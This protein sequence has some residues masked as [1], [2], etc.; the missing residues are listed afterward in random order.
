MLSRVRRSREEA[1]RMARPAM[2]RTCEGWLLRSSLERS[3]KFPTGICLD[4]VCV[5]IPHAERGM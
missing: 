5:A 4:S 1:L 3:G 2:G